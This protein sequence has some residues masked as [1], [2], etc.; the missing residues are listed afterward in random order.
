VRLPAYIVIIATFVTIVKLMLDK[1]LPDLYESMGGFLALIVVNCI[2]LG[3]AEAFAS[4]NPPLYSAIDGISMGLG[5]TLSIS[6]L[7]GIRQLLGSVLKIELFLQPAGGFI[8]LGLLMVVFNTV[9]TYFKQKQQNNRSSKPHSV[10][11]ED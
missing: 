1:L 2:I 5:F 3:R 11:K 10:A 8:A 6:I 4:K 7:G 9:Y